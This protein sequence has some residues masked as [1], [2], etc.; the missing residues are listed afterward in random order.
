[1]VSITSNLP[2]GSR[3]DRRDI[4]AWLSNLAVHYAADDNERLRA[5]C[6]LSLSGLPPTELETG[7][8]RLRHNLATADILAHLR[9]DAE[10]LEAAVATFFVG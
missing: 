8:T 4:E 10:T 2:V 9:M 3:A 7:E 5:A 1:M 6:E